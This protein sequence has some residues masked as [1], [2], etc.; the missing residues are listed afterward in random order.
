MRGGR[1]QDGFDF[2]I[3]LEE[4]SWLMT[5]LNSLFHLNANREIDFAAE[6]ITEKEN[7]NDLSLIIY[8]NSMNE[9]R[10]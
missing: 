2:C 10:I 3:F 5:C 8:L 4:T 9:Y 7:L 6:Q 1:R